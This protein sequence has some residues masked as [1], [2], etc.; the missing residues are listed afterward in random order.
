MNWKVIWNRKHKI[1]NPNNLKSLLKLNGYESTTSSVNSKEWKKYTQYFIKKYK[2]GKSTNILDIGCGSGAFLIPFYKKTSNCFGID[3]S[4]E[5]IKYCRINMPKGKFIVSEASNLSKLNGKNFDIIFVN[6]VFQ[7]FKN[8]NYSKKVLKN[9][10]SISNKNTK[11][12]LLDIP[13]KNKY[14][15]WK[16]YIINKYSEKHFDSNYSKLKHQFYQKKMFKDFFKQRNFEVKISDQ[17][18]IKKVNS[19]FRFNVFLK[20]EKK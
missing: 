16:N 6:S 20:Y 19:K 12:F 17:K 2:I 11:I 4:K 3:Y 15:N 13:D 5:L 1:K 10:I 8:L 18:L 9:I 7:Y 14:N